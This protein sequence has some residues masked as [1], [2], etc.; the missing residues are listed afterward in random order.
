[1]E[2]GL[3]PRQFI[4][5]K[6]ILRAWNRHEFY[7]LI[8]YGPQGIGKSSYMLQVMYQ[9]Y[10][11]WDRVFQNLIFSLDDLVDLIKRTRESRWRMKL[12]GWDDAGVH[13]HKYVYFRR[14]DAA[15][16]I[17]AW[18]DVARTKVAGLLITTVNPRTLLKPMRE[19]LGIRYGKVTKTNSDYGRAV[20]V[21]DQL[22]MPT[23]VK[24]LKK[25]YVDYFNVRLPDK[26]YERYMMLREQFYWDVEARLLELVDKSMK[27]G[28]V[29]NEPNLMDNIYGV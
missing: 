12:I 18:L 7:G 13:G 28:K 1:M 4:T 10:G 3:G 20:V 17:S 15:A 6:N 24:F 16:L 11:D 22:L 29:Q 21:Y 19:S 25:N 26:V 14:R 23:D 27:V 8:I 2:E 9:V 5:T